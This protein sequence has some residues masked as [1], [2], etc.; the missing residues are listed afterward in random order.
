M[1]PLFQ[2]LHSSVID[3]LCIIICAGDNLFIAL[4]RRPSKYWKN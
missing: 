1:R 3:A 4:T 2:T